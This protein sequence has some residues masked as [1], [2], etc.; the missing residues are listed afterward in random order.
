MRWEGSILADSLRHRLRRETAMQHERVDAAYSRAD[1][2]DAA[3]LATFLGASLGAL[4]RITCAP[5]PQR[6]PAETLRASMAGAARR[7]LELL[8]A[9]CPPGA[10][11][12]TGGRAAL[13]GDAVLYV[14]GGARMGAAVLRRIWSRSHDPRV[15]ACHHYLGARFEGPSWP[16]VAGALD[17]RSPAGEAAERIVAD[18]RR[19]FEL[20][21][22]SWPRAGKFKELTRG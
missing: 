7:D 21:E 16:A 22:T 1:L 12:R 4:E 14:L 15:L 3:G 20:F 17:E 6:G 9:P 13:S 18:A 19:I 8:G 10:A 5:G 2:T 11:A